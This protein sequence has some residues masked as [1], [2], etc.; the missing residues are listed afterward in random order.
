MK[1]LKEPERAVGRF[2]ERVEALE[3]KLG[4][5]VFQLPG[6]FKPDRARLANFLEALPVDP[7]LRIR[8]PRS[9]LVPARDPGGPR[10]AQCRA[11][12]VR[13]R[14]PAGAARGHRRLRLHPPAR[15]WGAPIKARTATQ[16]CEPGPSASAPGP[17]PAATSTATSTMTTVAMHRTMPCACGACWRE[18]ASAQRPR[19]VKAHA[20]RSC[21]MSVRGHG[22]DHRLAH[23]PSSAGAGPAPPLASGSG[24]STAAT[25]AKAG[26]LVPVAFRA[27]APAAAREEVPGAEVLVA[28]ALRAA[29]AAARAPASGPWHCSAAGYRRG[30]T[31]SPHSTR[32]LGLFSHCM[33]LAIPEPLHVCAQRP[34]GERHSRRPP[35][36]LASSTAVLDIDRLIVLTDDL[37]TRRGA[38]SLSVP[39]AC[40]IDMAT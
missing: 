40:S 1:R 26:A 34:R 37:S 13:V 38:L 22:G 20:R 36:T 3:D 23:Q 2:F 24:I 6:R 14:G 21:G 33:S 35:R 29:A 9:G 31:R 18:V 8:V 17:K 11:L 15:P 12:P 5:I 39:A 10:R 28:A 27:V 4:P 19:V 30:A 7:S 25:R 16:R 32:P